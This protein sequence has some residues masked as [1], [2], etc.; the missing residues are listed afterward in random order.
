MSLAVAIV[1]AG[2]S[3]LYCAEAINRKA[4]AARIDVVDRLATPYGLVRFGVAPDHQGTK[5]VTR[6]F[7]RLLQKPG[8]RFVGAVELGRDIAL[9]ELLA[10]YDAVVIACGAGIDR[11]LGIPGEDRANVFGSAAFVGWYNGHPDFADLPVNLREV[12][13]VAVV[14]NG[15]VAIDVARVLAKT[16][17]EMGKSDLVPH[18]AAAIA[19]APIRQI[20]ILGRRGPVEASFT[21]V[22]LAELGRLEQ[23]RPIVQGRDLPESAG[24]Q[25]PAL[26]KVKEANLATLRVFAA[27]PPDGRPIGI[28]FHFH[29]TPTRITGDSMELQTSH[30]PA[31]IG[32]DLVVSC[33]GYRCRPLDGIPMDEA[34]GIV[35]NVDGLVAPRLHVVGW[36]RRGPSGVIAT[37]RADAIGV[38]ERLLAETRADPDKPGPAGLDRRLGE[39]A[40]RAITFADWKRIEAAETD[41]AAGSEAPRVKFVRREEI[42]RVLERNNEAAQ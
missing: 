37:N 25:E 18:A 34:R 35:A 32:A 4:P 20:H 8:I 42:A 33:I 1:G 3:G 41:A 15:N 22:E 19:G 5:V 38:S 14:G 6:V 21:N 9:D 17:T 10:D 40:I 12:R 26:M 13:S 24:M 30:G 31:S 29:S 7:D 28:H 36:A 39:R 27:L 11:R 23:A 16:P 2:P